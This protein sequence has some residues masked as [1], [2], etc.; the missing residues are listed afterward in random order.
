MDSKELDALRKF[1]RVRE[2]SKCVNFFSKYPL[3]EECEINHLMTIEKV[4][5]CDTSPI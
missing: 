2:T 3:G 4:I 5:F 1:Y